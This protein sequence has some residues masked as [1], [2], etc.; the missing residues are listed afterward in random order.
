[1]NEDL[2]KAIVLGRIDGVNEAIAA[3]A[4]VNATDIDGRTPLMIAV[5]RQRYEVCT[6]L[7]KLGSNPT[8]KCNAGDD[9]LDLAAHTNQFK[10]VD[11]FLK[12]IYSQKENIPS[13]E[14]LETSFFDGSKLDKFKFIDS[15]ILKIDATYLDILGSITSQEAEIWQLRFPRTGHRQT[16][17]KIGDRYSLSRQRIEQIIKKTLRKLSHPSR[18]DPIFSLIHTLEEFAEEQGIERK[19]LLGRVSTVNQ[20][21]LFFCTLSER[22]SNSE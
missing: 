10:L 7:L 22:D 8:I 6:L 3:G 12:W 20:A 11:I 9:A 2:L 17:Q 4:N 18:R 14:H 16:L 15:L 1:M 5:T 19:D 21:L 13:H